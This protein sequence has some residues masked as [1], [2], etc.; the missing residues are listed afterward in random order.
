MLWDDNDTDWMIRTWSQQHCLSIGRQELKGELGSNCS[1]VDRSL[2]EENIR[3]KALVKELQQTVPQPAREMSVEKPSLNRSKRADPWH[4]LSILPETVCNLERLKTEII[5]SLTETEFA[6]KA[7]D[8]DLLQSTLA[9]S[10]IG[11]GELAVRSLSSKYPCIYKIGLTKNPVQRWM[12]KEYGY[13]HDTRNRFTNMTVIFA[14]AD[15]QP[16][17]FLEAALIRL[18]MGLPG[19]RNIQMG[20]EGLDQE[21]AGPYFCYVVYRKLIPP[22]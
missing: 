22:R 5:P 6:D 11:H 17:G 21:G 19:N 9:S 14:H 13:K 10:V 1:T 4:W 2:V 8:F 16:V 3:L 18:F 7:V 12:N 20:G 15:P